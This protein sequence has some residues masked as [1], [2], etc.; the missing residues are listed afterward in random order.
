MACAL[1]EEWVAVIVPFLLLRVNL[2]CSI[3]LKE[4]HNSHVLIYSFHRFSREEQ[5]ML[6]KK[7]KTTSSKQSSKQTSWPWWEDE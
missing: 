6:K 5:E 3:Q 4:R 1:A 7:W 2:W